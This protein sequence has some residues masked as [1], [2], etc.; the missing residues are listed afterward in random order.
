[1]G[2]EMGVDKGGGVWETGEPLWEEAGLGEKGEAWGSPGRRKSVG[3]SFL[4]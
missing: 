1:M 4:A 2:S 3:V